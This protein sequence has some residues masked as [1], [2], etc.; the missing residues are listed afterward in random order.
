MKTLDRPLQ[1]LEV[2]SNIGQMTQDVSPLL[3][4]YALTG[5]IKA[6]DM[7]TRDQDK[8]MDDFQRSRV[9]AK[10]GGQYNSLSDFVSRGLS[11][12]FFA[13]A[14]SLDTPLAKHLIEKSRE[15]AFGLSN[16]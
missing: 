7:L 6:I 4:Q 12:A 8:V 13:N 10:E 5:T 3:V 14:F 9:L 2:V 16:S 15:T 1:K 11:L